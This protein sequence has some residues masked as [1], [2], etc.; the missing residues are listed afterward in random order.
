MGLDKHDFQKDG[1]M[2]ISGKEHLTNLHSW[3]N[4][5]KVATIEWLHQRMKPK[6]PLPLFNT[7]PQCE[8]L[9]G[10]NAQVT[11]KVKVGCY[12]IEHDGRVYTIPNKHFQL[13][14]NGLIDLSH[15]S[16]Q[17]CPSLDSLVRVVGL[18]VP[19]PASVLRGRSPPPSSS[20]SRTPKRRKKRAEQSPPRSTASPGRPRKRRRKKS[21]PGQKP[22][23]KVT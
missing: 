5:D 22:R 12:T 21:P 9:D 4:P 7:T 15:Y 11:H 17:G 19:E 6:V 8:M 20:S 1:T 18:T 13:W 2:T 10:S 16:E 3:L 23:Q 14:Y